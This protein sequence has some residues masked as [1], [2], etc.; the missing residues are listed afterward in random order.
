[1][2]LGSLF[3]QRDKIDRAISSHKHIISRSG[4]DEQQRTRALRELGEDYMQAGLLDRAEQLFS[5]LA[6]ENRQDERSARQQIGR[7]SC[8]ERVKTTVSSGECNKKKKIHE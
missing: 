3:G 7:A 2:A 5:R 1:M 6:E 8:R 4:L